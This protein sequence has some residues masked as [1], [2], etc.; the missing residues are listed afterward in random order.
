MKF[1]TENDI[2]KLITDEQIASTIT[3]SPDIYPAPTVRKHVSPCHIQR[4]TNGKLREG[5]GRGNTWSKHSIA[6]AVAMLVAETCCAI[7]QHSPTAI[8]I[9][10]LPAVAPQPYVKYPM[11]ARSSEKMYA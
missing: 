5:Q 7:I 3:N 8:D 9:Q 6:Y 11:V 4:Q 1:C 2:A 10:W